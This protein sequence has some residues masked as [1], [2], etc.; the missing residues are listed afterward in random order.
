MTTMLRKSSIALATIA[1]T[2]C[3]PHLG[4]AEDNRPV[5]FVKPKLNVGQ[6]VANCQKI[7]GTVGDGGQGA[8]NSRSVTCQ[9]DNGLDVQC[10]F[11]SG[12][13]THCSGYG[14]RPQ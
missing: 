3:A 8:G 12:Q 2:F 14:P 9:K 5:V 10:E 11:E 13:Q 4:F 6:F 7:G 1:F